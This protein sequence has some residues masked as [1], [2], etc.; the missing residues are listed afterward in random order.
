MPLSSSPDASVVPGTGGKLPQT[1]QDT[2][3]TRTQYVPGHCLGGSGVL[4][5][6]QTLLGNWCGPVV[7]SKQMARICLDTSAHKALIRWSDFT[8]RKQISVWIAPLAGLGLLGV[9]AG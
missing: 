5:G 2:R 3:I 4:W 8:R 7:C 6:G 1:S 9:L